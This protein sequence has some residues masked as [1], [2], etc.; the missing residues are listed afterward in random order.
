MFFLK[1]SLRFLI[2]FSLI[3]SAFAGNMHYPI[4][5][6][7]IKFSGSIDGF[8]VVCVVEFDSEKAKEELFELIYISQK[9]NLL[10][11]DEVDKL[12]KY[13]D[14]VKFSTVDQLYKLKLNQRKHECRNYLKIFERFNNKKIEE[15]E[16]LQT[17]RENMLK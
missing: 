1:N 3:N 6:N 10:S 17:I 7:L 8:S 11:L 16:K 15:L 5:S 14:D 4:F 2:L 13:Y 9:E 12:D